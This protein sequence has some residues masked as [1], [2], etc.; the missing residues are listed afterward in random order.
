M[1]SFKMLPILA[2]AAMLFAATAF[3]D[4]P[5]LSQDGSTCA[6]LGLFCGS[7]HEAVDPNTGIDTVEYVFSTLSTGITP[8]PGGDWNGWVEGT[9]GGQEAELLDF[10]E[11]GSGPTA[12]YAVF[13]YCGG[14]KVPAS[15]PAAGI[16][17]A[18][19][20][21]LPLSENSKVQTT[22]AMTLAGGQV[23]GGAYNS[24]NSAT[25]AGGGKYGTGSAQYSVITN[26]TTCSGADGPC[27]LV[28]TAP[29]PSGA[30]LLGIMMIPLATLVRRKFSA[31]A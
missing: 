16:C 9:I 31:R 1:T 20:D 23:T 13:L 30:L 26:G 28:G 18:K 24:Q 10:V 25:L 4:D 7:S 5:S 29:E 12:Q 2:A 17:S 8:T 27:N 19:D 3:A 22:Y 15:S 11:T 6:T 14:Y 21:F